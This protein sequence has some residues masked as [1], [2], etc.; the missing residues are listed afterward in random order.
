[1]DALTKAFQMAECGVAVHGLSI[2]ATMHAE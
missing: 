2:R 1:M